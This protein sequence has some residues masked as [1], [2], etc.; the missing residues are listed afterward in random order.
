VRA[1]RRFFFQRIEAR[2]YLF[3]NRGSQREVRNRRG[4]QSET[5]IEREFF[6]FG[7]CPHAPKNR[8]LIEAAG[9]VMKALPSSRAEKTMGPLLGQIVV[10]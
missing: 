7:H 10:R 9:L 3:I 8:F 5:E 1:T 2:G 6:E 4:R